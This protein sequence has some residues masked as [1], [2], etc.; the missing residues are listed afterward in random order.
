[1]RLLLLLLLDLNLRLGSPFSI[2]ASQCDE[3]QYHSCWW[4]CIVVRAEDIYPTRDGVTFHAG[5]KKEEKN[6][7]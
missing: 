4:H 2:A 6:E 7:T 5:P 1:M 3:K